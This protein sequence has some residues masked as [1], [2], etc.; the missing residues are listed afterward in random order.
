MFMM[1]NELVASGLKN[2]RVYFR[3]IQRGQKWFLFARYTLRESD[4]RV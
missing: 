4:R 2:G 3:Y 1:A